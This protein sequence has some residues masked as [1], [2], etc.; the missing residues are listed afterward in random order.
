LSEILTLISLIA[1]NYIYFVPT[2]GFIFNPWI[3]VTSFIIIPFIYFCIGLLVY[4]IGLTSKPVNANIIAQVFLPIFINVII[5]VPLRVNI[6]DSNSWTFALANIGLALLIV[7]I[8]IILQ[9][10]ISKEKIVLSY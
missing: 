7:I 10:R 8:V 6:I 9:F 2:V 4:L 3:A 5:Q 1:V